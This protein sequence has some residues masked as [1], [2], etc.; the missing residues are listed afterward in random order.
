MI[1]EIAAR[2]LLLISS[3]DVKFSTELPS[4]IASRHRICTNIAFKLKEAGFLGD[5][6]YNQLLYP[7]E[8]QTRA[9]LNWLVLKLPRSKE[10]STEEA[11]GENAVLN[12]VIIDSLLS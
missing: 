8:Q 6:G 2:S 7:V 1:V 11:L 9:L 5:C 4:N 12:K 3:G 10:E